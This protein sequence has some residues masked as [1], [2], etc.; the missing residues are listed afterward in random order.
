M[1]KIGVAAESVASARKQLVGLVQEQKGLFEALAKHLKTTPEVTGENKKLQG[2][3][4]EDDFVISSDIAEQ[5]L[6]ELYGTLLSGEQQI[7]RTYM[8]V[9][10]GRLSLIRSL[11]LDHSRTH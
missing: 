10:A 1:P 7:I 4:V 9:R 6:G 2:L 3:S 8:N 11:A 5:S